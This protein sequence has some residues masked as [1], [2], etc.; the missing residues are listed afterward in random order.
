M[1]TVRP[2]LRVVP[3]TVDQLFTA[4]LSRVSRSHLIALSS[5]LCVE[6][7]TVA[8]DPGA[9]DRYDA[10]VEEIESRSAPFI[11]RSND[12]QGS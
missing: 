10:L 1:N 9:R 2:L 5:K 4:D 8:P 7:D 3:N 12:A 11:R 6:L